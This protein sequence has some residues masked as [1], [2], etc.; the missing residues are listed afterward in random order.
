[1]VNALLLRCVVLSDCFYYTRQAMPTIAVISARH[2]ESNSRGETSS[3][4]KGDFHVTMKETGT[5][6]GG[7]LEVRARHMAS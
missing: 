3:C 5:R 4:F 7:G 1:M 2:P 6:G